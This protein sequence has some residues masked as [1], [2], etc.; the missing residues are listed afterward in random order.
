MNDD[1]YTGDPI[2][3]EVRAIRAQIAAECEYD[4]HR[5]NEH[6]RAA[7]ENMPGLTYV[8]VEQMRERR[9]RRAEAATVAVQR[10]PQD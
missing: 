2:V 1:D 4:L 3:G 9:R 8:S 5:I 10:T 6:A 7:T